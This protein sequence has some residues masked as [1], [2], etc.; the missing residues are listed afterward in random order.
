MPWSLKNF[1]IKRVGVVDS[2]DNPEAEVVLFKSKEDE[3]IKNKGGAN[4]SKTFEELVKGLPEEEAKLVTDEIEK[5]KTEAMEKAKADMI[6]EESKKK[7]ADEEKV[8]LNKSEEELIKSADPKVRELLEKAKTEADEAKKKVDELQKEK[9]KKDAELKK[10]LLNKEAEKYTN[11]GATKEDIV[12]IFEVTDGKE[13]ADKLLKGILSATNEAL[14]DNKLMK[15][16]G[17]DGDGKDKTAREEVEEKAQELVKSE[18]ITIEKARTKVYKQ[19]PD[20]M[21]KEREEEK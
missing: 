15:V 2:G 21:K 11:I 19:N 3:D 9:D 17:S 18:K 10:E 14:K 20:L 8:K 1:L 4:M 5:V 6:D 16:I 7:L 12:K 13:E